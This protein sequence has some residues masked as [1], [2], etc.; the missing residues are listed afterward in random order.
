MIT[1]SNGETDFLHELLLANTQVA[2]LLNVFEN[3]LSTDIKLS[4]TQLSRMMQSGRFLVSEFFAVIG[5]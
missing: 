5:M 1:N 4:K 2:N 3:N